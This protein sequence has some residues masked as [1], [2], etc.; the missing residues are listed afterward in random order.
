MEKE[1]KNIEPR[2]MTSSKRHYYLASVDEN[3]NQLIKEEIDELT[4]VLIELKSQYDIIRRESINKKSQTDELCKKIDSLQ[5]MDKKSKKKIDDTN[6]QSEDLA[7]SIKAKKTRL[8]ECLYEMKTLQI[9]RASCR[10]RV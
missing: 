6:Q 4:R 8:N 10:E 9:G 7:N 5:K 3:V 2:Y 1:E